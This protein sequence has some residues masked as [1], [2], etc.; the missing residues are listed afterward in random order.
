MLGTIEIIQSRSEVLLKPC[1]CFGGLQLH[2]FLLTEI[3][4]LPLPKLAAKC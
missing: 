3:Y 1:K 4:E 2:L